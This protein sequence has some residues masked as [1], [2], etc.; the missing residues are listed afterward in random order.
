MIG[1]LPP[2]ALGTPSF[3]FRALAAHAGRASLGGDREVALAC[4][5]SARLASGLLPP[6][7]LMTLEASARA[8]GARQWLA[9]LTLPAPVRSC[10]AAVIDATAETNGVAAARALAN[11]M[12]L[13]LPQ[14]DEASFAELR[15]LADVLAHDSTE[16]QVEHVLPH[17]FNR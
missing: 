7:S 3:R 13:V 2:F 8:A 14:L 4:F 5:V 12:L 17:N 10:V 1:Q 6:L 15:E 16:F 9:S 11:L